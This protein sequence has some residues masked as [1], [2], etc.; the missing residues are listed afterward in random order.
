MVQPREAVEGQYEI[1]SIESQ[2]VRRG[3]VRCRRRA[4]VHPGDE[5]EQLPTELLI[6][7]ADHAGFSHR[8][9]MNDRR[10]PPLVRLSGHRGHRPSAGRDVSAS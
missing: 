2:A 7:V 9:S 5:T 1:F 8:I 10:R 4:A 3:D 6:E